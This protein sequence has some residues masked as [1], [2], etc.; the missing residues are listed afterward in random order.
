MKCTC[1]ECGHAFEVNPYVESD[2]PIRAA[3]RAKGL[4]LQEAATALGISPWT[5]RDLERG[6]MNPRLSVV[7]G[8]CKLY[9]KPIEELFPDTSDEESEEEVEFVAPAT[10]EP[11]APAKSNGGGK[12]GKK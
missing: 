6:K 2:S 1:P 11:V 5:V 3:R 7:L 12:S 8:V 4:T 9:E 10:A